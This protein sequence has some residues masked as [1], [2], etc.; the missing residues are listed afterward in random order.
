MLRTESTGETLAAHHHG[1]GLAA[2]GHAVREDRAVQTLQR[3]AHHACRR[4]RV[5][6]W[7]NKPG[8]GSLSARAAL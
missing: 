7:E 2:A 6:L 1:E 4:P 5:Y 8:A 3:A